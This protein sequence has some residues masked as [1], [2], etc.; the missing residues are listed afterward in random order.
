VS[1]DGFALLFGPDKPG[2]FTTDIPG[3][4]VMRIRIFALPSLEDHSP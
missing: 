4:I 1:S 3:G 2:R